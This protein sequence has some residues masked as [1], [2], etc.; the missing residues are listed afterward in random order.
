LY[1]HHIA[2]SLQ[3]AIDLVR[4]KQPMALNLPQGC[5]I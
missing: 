5:I 2:T 3:K 4:P 1:A